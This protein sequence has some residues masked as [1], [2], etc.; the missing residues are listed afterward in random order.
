[1][2]EKKLSWRDIC[3]MKEDPPFFTKVF[4]DS[5]IGMHI[6]DSYIGMHI[7]DSYIDMTV[8]LN[9]YIGN[10]PSQWHTMNCSGTL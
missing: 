3:K 10:L 8:I 1:M 5:Y 4:L 7:L 6:L 2:R 9:S